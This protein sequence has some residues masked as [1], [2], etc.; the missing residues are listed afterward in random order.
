[1]DRT[2]PEFISMSWYSQFMAS[3]LLNKLGARNDTHNTIR[4]VISANF[5]IVRFFIQE[6]VKHT[7]C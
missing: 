3:R 7:H 4:H 2:R 6:N 5:F 1:M